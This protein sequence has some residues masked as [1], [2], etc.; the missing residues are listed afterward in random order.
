MT[1]ELQTTRKSR[2]AT[3]YIVSLKEGS[4][5]LHHYLRCACPPCP[6]HWLLGNVNTDWSSDV[7]THMGLL[8]I[9]F[10]TFYYKNVLGLYITFKKKKYKIK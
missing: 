7:I 6:K 9:T 2:N 8:K 4:F 3:M 10:L 1:T 5:K